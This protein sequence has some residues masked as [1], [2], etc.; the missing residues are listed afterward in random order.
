MQ[1]QN[2]KI[3][4]L[5]MLLVG[6]GIVGYWG[7]YVYKIA[8]YAMTGSTATAKVIGYKVS[9]YGTRMVKNPSSSKSLFSGRSPFFEFTTANGEVIK[10]YSR[11]PQI[12]VLFNYDIDETI[13]VA[14]PSTQPD[15]AVVVSCKEF[16]GLIFMI[17]FGLL[18]MIVGKSFIFPKI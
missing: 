3:I 10:D 7:L 13:R 15:K 16:P 17:L 12:F 4:G 8:N 5:I 2:P 6:L 9:G 11:S 1:I 14:Y 18:C